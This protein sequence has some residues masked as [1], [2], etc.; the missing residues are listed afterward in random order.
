M[1][2]WLIRAGRATYPREN[3]AALDNWLDQVWAF[4]GLI[5]IGDLVV[6]PYR[7][8]PAVAVGPSPVP[9]SAGRTSAKAPSTSGPWSGSTV[10]CGCLSD[11][12]PCFAPWAA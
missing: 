4:C 6:L 3:P 2:V 7:N 11:L 1:S 8:R 10:A 9:T 12:S 5:Q